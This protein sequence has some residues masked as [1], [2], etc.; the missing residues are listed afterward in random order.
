MSNVKAKIFIFSLLI[1][2]AT[3]FGSRVFA[4][5]QTDSNSVKTR[6]GNPPV[7]TVPAPPQDIRQGIIDTFGVTMNGFGQDHLAWTW[8]RL[9]EVSNTKFVGLIKGSRVEATTGLSSQAGCFGG[10]TSLYLGQYTSR[11][12][13]KF[14]LLH[15]FGHVI[16]ACHPSG[17]SNHFAQKN[18]FAVEGAI[19]YYA[20]NAAACTGSSS[21]SEDYADMIAYYLDSSAG[22]SSGP[23]GGNCGPANPPNPFTSGGFSSHKSAAKGA[24]E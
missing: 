20:Q 24:L 8:E 6:V 4:Q 19:S 5:L 11:E 16:Q 14:I 10:G 21:L 22:F 15:E 1:I 23:G 17:I 2:L 13:F 9:W 12:F 3:I 18:A 7:G